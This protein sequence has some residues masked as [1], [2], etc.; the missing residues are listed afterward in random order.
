VCQDST[1]DHTV[2][3]GSGRCSED[4]K[5]SGSNLSAGA[6]IAIAVVVVASI[7]VTAIGVFWYRNRKAIDAKLRRMKRSF[8]PRSASNQ[9]P[10]V[11]PR[12]ATTVKPDTKPHVTTFPAFNVFK[13]TTNPQPKPDTSVAVINAQPV[14]SAQGSVSWKDRIGLSKVLPSAKSVEEHDEEKDMNWMQRMRWSQ[15]Q[16]TTSPAQPK[17]Q[18]LKL[19]QEKDKGK[20]KAM[21][22]EGSSSS[23]NALR[24]KF[25]G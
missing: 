8:H 15:V 19:K 1:A 2:T 11:T 18:K 23:V 4:S 5:A 6:K 17:G 14:A 16:H 20:G 13:T 22:G 10:I 3:S 12:K 25:G 7:L 21:W 24:A 9:G